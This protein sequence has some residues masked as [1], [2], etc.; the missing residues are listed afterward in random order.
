MQQFRVAV[1]GALGAVGTEMIKTL[2]QRRFPVSAL[3]PID[4]PELAGRRVRYRGEEV[5]VRGAGKGA[6]T[7]VDIALF[8]AGAEASL[9]LAPIA[10]AEGAVVIDN[11]SA[12]RMD[13]QVPLVVPEVNPQALEGHKGLIANPN[14]STIQMVVALKP[15]HD[16][17]RIKRIVVATYQAVS[18]AGTPAIE[19]LKE[20]AREY[21]AGRRL[22][23]RVFPKQILFNAIPHIDVFQE[24]GYTKEEM[25]MVHETHK[26]LDPGI[27]VSPTAVRVGVF[28]GHSES[29]NVET[30]KGFS[31]D[32]VRKLLEKAP[33][34]VVMDNPERKEYPTALDADGQDAVYV[35]RLRI[36]PTVPHGLN[37]WVVSDNLRKGAALNAVQI[38]EELVKR[39]L[40]GRR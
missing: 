27:A 26:I 9:E 36:D 4:M 33:G 2:E 18:G 39:Q 16:A 11:S 3:I 17:Y 14:C 34:V 40:V 1:V 19:E 35:G 31:L 5:T 20:Q 25:K 37:M 38:A 7:D 22:E 8:S 29:V 10:V 32:E 23:A 6:F 28:R 15:I 30:E 24:N 12:W 13:P 21:V